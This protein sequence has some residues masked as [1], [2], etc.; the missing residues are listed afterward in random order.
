MQALG[1]VT[2]ADFTQLMAGGWAAQKLGD[3][4]ADVI[5][6]EPPGGEFQREMSY[7]G[8][9]LDE[10]GIGHLA[11]NRN[12]RS[13]A[14]DLKTD[15]GLGVAE[16]IVE[17]ADVL[18][19]NFR[20]G[21]MERLGL[22]YDSVAEINPEIVY[23]S[24][25]AYGEEGPYAERPGQDLL[26]QASTGLASYTGRAGEPPTPAGTVVV[27]E[28]TATLVAL[29]T[30]HALYYRER[31]GEGQKI[32]GS[33][34]NAAID[35]QCNEITFTT[36][37]GTSLERGAKTQGH[38]YL[39]PP[40]GIYETTDGHVAIGQIPIERVA[41]ALAIDALREY[42]S[43][44]ELFE[45]RDRI[46]D[47]IEEHTADRETETVVDVLVKADIQA[48]AVEP[49]ED[50][51]DHPQATHA[52]MVLDV[53]HPN[54]GEFTT[55]GVPV[56]HSETPG[57][58]NRRPPSVGEHNEEVLAELGFETEEIDRF[59]EDGVIDD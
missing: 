53:D 37:T 44:Q 24:V 30:M 7:S 51:V 15:E 17:E 27:D 35:L 14:L 52:D 41:D 46:H 28:H 23:V 4:G 9:Y 43:Q 48:A 13:V 59:R 36:N 54:G 39:Y 40:Y 10:V 1:D 2:V 25:S 21:V 57:R 32:E 8:E 45:N 18:M 56:K 29:H 58:V 11:M 49:P 3:M 55:T 42:D 50:I 34:F 20:P 47:I 12:K 31:T 22:D 26:Y 19:Q 5:K 6:I 33:L 38:P 16:R